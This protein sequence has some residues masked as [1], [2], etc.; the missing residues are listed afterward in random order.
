MIAAKDKEKTNFSASTTW[1]F[2]YSLCILYFVPIISCFYSDNS[3]KNCA[4]TFFIS[5]ITVNLKSKSAVIK[6]YLNFTE[7]KHLKGKQFAHFLILF[8]LKS[9]P[10]VC[11][12]YGESSYIML[13]YIL[14]SI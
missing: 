8:V 1:R 9:L 14:D 10:F 4:A 2:F 5:T 12:C 7:Y 13:R 6:H 3:V 11:Y